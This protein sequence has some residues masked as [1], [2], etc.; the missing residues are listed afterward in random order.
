MD[1]SE[2]KE[3]QVVVL[4][5]GDHENTQEQAADQVMATLHRQG[6]I[7]GWRV[8]ALDGEDEPAAV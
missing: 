5:R 7:E 3:V 8:P 6:R 1:S 4:I 2:L